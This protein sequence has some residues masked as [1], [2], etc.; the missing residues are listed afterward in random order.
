MG[1]A[2]MIT[3]QPRPA[4]VHRGESATLHVVAAGSEP[5]SYQWYAGTDSAS[6]PV[7]GA[8][9]STFVTPPITSPA[10][11]WVRV[12]NP[13]GSVDSHPAP[14]I[15]LPIVARASDLY[16]KS[17]AGHTVTLAWTDEPGAQ[18]VTGHVLEIG[19]LGYG[20]TIA[21]LSTGS[22]ASTFTF[23]APT[24]AFFVRAR[25]VSGMTP[26]DASAAIALCV[27]TTCP[28]IT[29]VNLLGLVSGTDVALAWRSPLESGVPTKI[30]LDVDGSSSASLELPGTAESFAYE[31]VPGSTFDFR[32]AACTA[33][34]CSPPTAPI[35]LEFPGTC[36]G[37][38]AV[39]AKFAV[40]TAGR[41]VTVDWELPESGPAPTS[42]VL[43][44]SG[45]FNDSLPT[46]GRRL[47]GT[48]GPGDYMV[49]VAGVNACGTGAA[50]SP[51]RLT[52]P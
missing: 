31:G 44:V 10:R 42:Y 43:A 25:A 30:V 37:P 1:V 21:E 12:S 24:G 35:R 51:I 4:R 16:V 49:S 5:L 15:P 33:A 7:P 9:G 22:T 32:V 2:P 3:S 26:G 46:A 17:M 23:I 11:F 45:S 52:I 14:V 40:A 48:V 36:S 6:T 8:T 39:P 27:N 38:P 18:P 28:A 34:G 50:T 19:R 13:Y 20:R 47:S 41:T 29:P